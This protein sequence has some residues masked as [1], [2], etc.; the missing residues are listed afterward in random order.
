[1][2]SSESISIPVRPTDHKNNNPS[3]SHFKSCI[4]CHPVVPF[5][6][7]KYKHTL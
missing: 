4:Q 5:K 3:V 7:A 6:L 1:M 2:E